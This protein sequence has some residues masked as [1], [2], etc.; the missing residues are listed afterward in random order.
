MSEKND[1]GTRNERALHLALKK[2][3]DGDESHHE[4]PVCGSVAD[5][6]DGE[7]ITEIETRSFSNLRK[8][9]GRFLESGY[10]VTVVFPV[11]VRTFFSYVG[12]DGKPDKKHLSTKRG[13]PS[14]ILTEIMKISEYVGNGRLSFRVIT[15]EVTEYRK[16][17]KRRGR[18]S[19]E[20]I[21]RFPSAFLDDFRL[22]SA[23]E[24]AGLV[25]IPHGPFSA[26][27]FARANRLSGFKAW[28]EL[29]ALEGTGIVSC[30]KKNRPF[31]YKR[32][33]KSADM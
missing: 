17:C 16:R 6:L 10:Q 26:G 2:Y 5:I 8:K 33:D 22:S 11:A 32:I 21:E 24:L 27:E 1:I 7:I 3:I 31:V 12:Q 20:V 25:S 30:D 23:E 29:K 15:L 4:I 28:K 14:D 13:R 18:E 19:F 9:L